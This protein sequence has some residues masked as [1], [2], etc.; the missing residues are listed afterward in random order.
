MGSLADRNSYNSAFYASIAA[1]DYDIFVATPDFISG[2]TFN[3]SKVTLYPQ[4]FVSPT[5]VQ[6]QLSTYENLTNSEC[7]AAYSQVIST[8]RRTVVIVSSSRNA[9][10]NNSLLDARQYIFN[11]SVLPSYGSYKPFEW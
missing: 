8:E 11:E 9:T 1:V 2:G 7:I 4:N 10:S 6:Q 3:L 5:S